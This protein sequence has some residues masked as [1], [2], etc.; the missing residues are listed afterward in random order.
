MIAI[1]AVIASILTV[2][3]LLGFSHSD[4]MAQTSAPESQ[5]RFSRRRRLPLSDWMLVHDRREE[6]DENPP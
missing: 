4:S 5:N 3:G 1:L 2:G 6:L